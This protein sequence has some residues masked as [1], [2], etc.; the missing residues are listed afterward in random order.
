MRKSLKLYATYLDIIDPKMGEIECTD[1]IKVISS[2]I[3][4]N[5]K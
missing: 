2:R 4:F 1:F 3:K 5:A